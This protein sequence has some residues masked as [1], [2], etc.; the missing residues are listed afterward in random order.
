MG[1]GRIAGVLSAVAGR[2]SESK[3]LL[4]AP[5]PAWRGVRE[6]AMSGQQPRLSSATARLD[7]AWLLGRGASKSMTLLSLATALRSTPMACY[8]GQRELA[9]NW[10]TLVAVERSNPS[11]RALAFL[12][13]RL[14]FSDGRF[15]DV[16]DG[17]RRGRVQGLPEADTTLSFACYGSG[18][19]LMRTLGGR[20]L[21]AAAGDGRVRML[22]VAEEPTSPQTTPQTVVIAHQGL[23]RDAS[24]V[25]LLLF[26]DALRG[27]HMPVLFRV[28]AT[29]RRP[30]GTSGTMTGEA[31]A[32]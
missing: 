27:T 22:A 11:L 18:L 1:V 17:E 28:E 20:W 12:G 8:D 19:A 23:T 14:L 32:P 16:N 31:L 26:E 21:S 10:S 24:H 25:A 2:D 6:D 3:D 29:E 4:E 5:A 9:R 30:A 13:S 15:V 7:V